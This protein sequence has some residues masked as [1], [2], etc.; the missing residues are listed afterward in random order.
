MFLLQCPAM[1]LSWNLLGQMSKISKFSA[2][3]LMAITYIYI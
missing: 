2:S 1:E 3:V